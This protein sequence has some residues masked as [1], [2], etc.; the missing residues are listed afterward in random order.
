M[1]RILTLS[2]ILVFQVGV[3]IAKPTLVKHALIVAI[4]DYPEYTNWKDISSTNDVALIKGALSK[5]GFSDFDVLENENATKADIIKAF[6]DLK[7]RCNPGD[8]VVVHFSSHGQQI[9]DDNK[10]ELDGY[11]EAIVAYGAPAY[12]D[13][14]YNGENH[15]RD[16]EL[17]KKLDDIRQQIGKSG[18]LLVLID[19]CHSGTGTRGGVARGGVPALAPPGYDPAKGNS[20]EIGMFEKNRVTS[21][22]GD[23]MS[24][25]VVISAA[26]ANE[27]NYEFDG[28]GSLSVAFSRSFENLNSKYSYRSL[29]SK[30]VKEMSVIA[31]KQT[32]ALEGDVD[33]L[34]FGGKV[35]IQE[36]YYEVTNLDADAMS[37]DGG[38]FTGL[39]EET[40]IKVYPA[41]TM[42][43]KGKEPIT[44]GTIVYTEAFSCNAILDEELEGKA[45]DYWVFAEERSF[46][47]LSIALN[48]E[49]IEDK[50]LKAN[51][52]KFVEGNNLV[53]LSSENAEFNVVEKDGKIA[54]ER[55]QDGDFFKYRSKGISTKIFP[56]DD[57][58]RTLKKRMSNYAQ[59]KFLKSLEINN[60]EY[61]VE[62]QLVPVLVADKKVS[63]TLDIANFIDNGGMPNFSTKD[64]AILRITNNSNFPVYFNI[65]DIQPDGQVNP[66]VPN[67]RRNENAADFKIAAGQT[68]EV[69]G[70]Y[71]TFS[72]PY[73]TETFK[74]FA[75]YSP[76]NFAPIFMTKGSGDTRGV[77][78][79]LEKL[80]ADS[81]KMTRGAD[82]GM[83]RADADA[84]TFSYTFKIVKPTK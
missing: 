39:N 19:A 38:A 79:D 3:F 54:L 75:S 76:L 74:V 1:K 18:D 46:G 43:T 31:P 15:L 49:K 60:P 40:V 78:N 71:I 65:I 12:Y 82:V 14:A 80:F 72:P 81:Y 77:E 7:S 57:G 84:C 22:G 48:L 6:N 68:Y 34:L 10:D 9:M 36:S 58:F 51:L 64:K 66:I 37:I 47:D 61:N 20:K 2:L 21:R 42:Q 63:D 5:Q 62:L 73:G 29:F 55:T 24:P 4:G 69:K 83:L 30:I 45:T 8:I 16:E 67:P 11:D 23:N 32:P 35:V 27:L 17:G 70:K 33:R 25:M 52:K 28:Y 59:G 41:G 44:T 13:E 50:S 53:S 26:R 56:V